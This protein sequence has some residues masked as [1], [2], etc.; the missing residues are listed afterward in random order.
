MINTPIVEATKQV[1]MKMKKLV[2]TFE[3]YRLSNGT[4][5]PTENMF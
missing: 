2:K 4:L 5:N 1:S 3:L